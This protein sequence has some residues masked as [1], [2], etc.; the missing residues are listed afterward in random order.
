M[1]ARYIAGLK[2]VRDFALKG[3][4]PA[5]HR[6]ICANLT[7]VLGW[8]SWAYRLVNEYADAWPKALRFDNGRVHDYCV[9]HVPDYYKWE[10]P[11]LEARLELID[12][13]IAQ[14]Q[15]ELAAGRSTPALL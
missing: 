15:A 4:L 1:I 11:N 8:D 10:G 14:L 6:G 5:A 12:C 13:I 3:C 2:E 9:P 7:H